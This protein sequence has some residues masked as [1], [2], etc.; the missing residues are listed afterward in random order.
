MRRLFKFVL[1]AALLAA[2]FAAYSYLG[3][4]FTAGRLLGVSPPLTG[5][6]VEFN[7]EGVPDLPG[8]PRAWV[9][10]YSRSKL[11]GVARAQIF[12]SYNGRVIATRPRDLQARLLA[13]EK[14]R[15]P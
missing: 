10:T 3:A 13:W 14:M 5:R 11:P 15:L 9:F 8:T 1:I 2:G 4:R 7:F 6:T 12:I